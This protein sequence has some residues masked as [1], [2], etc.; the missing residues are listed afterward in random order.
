[1]TATQ[2]SSLELPPDQS[3]SNV[4]AAGAFVLVKKHE[5]LNGSSKA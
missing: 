1:M 3:I 2:L 5:E 4:R